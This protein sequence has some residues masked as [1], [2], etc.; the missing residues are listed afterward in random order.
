MYIEGA[1][2]SSSSCHSLQSVGM[3]DDDRERHDELTGDQKQKGRKNVMKRYGSDSA[4]FWK[5]HGFCLALNIK[6]C[7]GGALKVK[8]CTSQ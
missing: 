5:E 7:Q 1:I 2:S 6:F 4:D 3:D 8:S